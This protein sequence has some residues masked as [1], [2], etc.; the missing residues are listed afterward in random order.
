LVQEFAEPLPPLRA[1]PQILKQVM[2]NLL[3]NAIKF[4]P[5]GG[6]ISIRIWVQAADGFVFQVV[7][8]GIGIAFD[9]IPK[10]LARFEQVDSRLSRKFEGTGL[11]LPLT[12]S[13]V[14]LHGGSVDLQSEVG[15][16]TTVTLRFPAE[17]ILAAEPAVP[18]IPAEIP[19]EGPA[20]VRV[21]A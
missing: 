15:V 18:E 9:D 1:D 20:E 8:T 21:P 3:S 17:R 2:I 10:A 7:D 4:T 11:G 6:T 5:A 16:G 13:L 14:E 19:V 12:K